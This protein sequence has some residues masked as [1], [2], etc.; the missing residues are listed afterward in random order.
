MRKA[1]QES[2]QR[3]QG[4][5]GRRRG[6]GWPGRAGL[7]TGLEDRAGPQAGGRASGPE[8]G[9]R[10]ALPEPPLGLPGFLGLGFWPGHLVVGTPCPHLR[11]PFRLPVSKHPSVPF[12]SSPRLK[13]PTHANPAHRSPLERSPRPPSFRE[14]FQEALAGCAGHRA[15]EFL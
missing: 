12:H 10:G 9:G 7:G 11:L 2:G 3:S 15:Q 1:Q 5:V 6:T 14:A 4:E 8:Q 13:E